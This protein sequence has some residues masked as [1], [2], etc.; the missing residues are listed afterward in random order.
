MGVYYNSTTVLSIQTTE[1]IN[2]TIMQKRDFLNAAKSGDKRV[3]PPGALWDIYDGSVWKSF[4]SP[5]C[6]HFLALSHCYLLTLNVDW[7]EPF[8]RGVNS[9]GAIYLIQNLPQSMRYSQKIS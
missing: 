5:S 7:F 2:F 6:Q 4:S 9:V 3:V 8:E 1:N